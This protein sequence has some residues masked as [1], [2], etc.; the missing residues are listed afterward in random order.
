MNLF[1]GPASARLKAGLARPLQYDT[2]AAAAAAA[3]AATAAAED[4]ARVIQ[5]LMVRTR[6][7]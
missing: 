7:G 4:Q 3:V 6:A 1:T 5:G 2:A